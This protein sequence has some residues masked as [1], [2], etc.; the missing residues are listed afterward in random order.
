MS[1]NIHDLN[2]AQSE[3]PT[4]FLEQ[5]EFDPNSFK[6]LLSAVID[7]G[8]DLANVLNQANEHHRPADTDPDSVP[9][10]YLSL[11]DDTQNNDL[12]FTNTPYFA[13]G[14]AG[15]DGLDLDQILLEDDLLFYQLGN[16]F[17]KYRS[18][19]E[20]YADKSWQQITNKEYF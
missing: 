20:Y 1:D 18:Q 19:D 11:L 13:D 3:L 16:W 2:T 10:T 4:V 7:F 5:L 9:N 14:T 17:A 12:A 15:D 6:D 8:R